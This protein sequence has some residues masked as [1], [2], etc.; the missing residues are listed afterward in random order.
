MTDI[1]RETS[2]FDFSDAPVYRKTATLDKSKLEVATKTQEV[3]TIVDGK[4]ETTNTANAGDK[5]ITGPKNE[6]YVIKQEKFG[7][8]YENDPNNSERYISKQVIRVVP[9]TEDTE[10]TPPWGGKQR[11]AKGGVAAQSLSNPTD[12][13]L[14]DEGAFKATYAVEGAKRPV[15]PV[16]AAK[17][18]NG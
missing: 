8:L 3:V 5:I 12:I 10:I 15:A 6:R 4:V 13:Y 2:S 1:Y 9:L 18:T 14:I 7:N 17:L 16:N 11:A